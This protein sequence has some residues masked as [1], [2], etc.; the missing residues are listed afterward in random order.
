MFYAYLLEIDLITTILVSRYFGELPM[1]QI[2]LLLFIVVPIVEITVLMQVGELI[3]GWPTVGLVVLS[4][5]IGA[6]FVKQQGLSTV[7]NL[8]LKMAQGE[9]P[10]NEI[11]AGLLLLVSGVL[12]VTPGF[13][14]DIFG[15]SLL[16]PQVRLALVNS[17][18]KQL[19]NSNNVQFHMH[20]QQ[21]FGQQP[22]GQQ[23]QNPFEQHQQ[24]TFEQNSA[25]KRDNQGTTLEGEFE[26][27]E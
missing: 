15:L 7:Q 8:Q 2:L 3:G 6:Y 25:P 16:I 13:I 18:K 5:W 10:S 19:V 22:F 14:T 1:F 20:G 24:N 4:A 9:M 27:K 17:V 11:V 23:Q 12:M 21:P 26:R